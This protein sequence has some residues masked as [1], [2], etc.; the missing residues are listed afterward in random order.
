MKTQTSDDTLSQNA[1]KAV[2][3]GGTVH[4]YSQGIVPFIAIS[5]DLFPGVD[6]DVCT[7]YVG[8]G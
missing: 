3:K 2:R 1:Y 8:D 6:N 5:C 4:I 7:T